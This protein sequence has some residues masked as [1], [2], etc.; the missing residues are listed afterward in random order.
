MSLLKSVYTLSTECCITCPRWYI[1]CT[2]YVLTVKVFLFTFS[3]LHNY[4]Q[5]PAGNCRPGHYMI[6]INQLNDFSDNSP[7]ALLWHYLFFRLPFFCV[8]GFNDQ[9]VQIESLSEKTWGD[10][11]FVDVDSR[12]HLVLLVPVPPAAATV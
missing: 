11:R 7:V 9:E 8:I 1:I 10:S 4:I 6:T 12:H 3:N 5:D 2:T